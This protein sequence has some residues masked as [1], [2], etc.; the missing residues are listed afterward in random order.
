MAFNH[1][2]IIYLLCVFIAL[3]ILSLALWANNDPK[4][5]TDIDKGTFLFQC[6]EHRTNG[7]LD[8]NG[9]LD[10]S[11]W[12]IYKQQ[13]EGWDT[14]LSSLNESS[15]LVL[16]QEA[17]LTQELKNYI[18][19]SVLEVAMAHAFRLW[20]TAFGVM[21][22]SKVSASRV[23]A[24]TAT[25][26]LIRFAKSG[27]VAIYPLSNGSEL[28]VVNLHGINFEWNLTHYKKQLEALAV[29]L[30]EHKGPIILAGDFNT[31]REERMETVNKFAQRFNLIEAQYGIDERER[32]FGYPLD[33]LFFRGLI[34]EG[35]E[36]K[37]TESSDHNPI[38]AHFVL[39]AR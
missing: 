39:P 7:A 32:V 20:D 2:R 38:T 36:A 11:V 19:N 14:L 21:N 31:W 3:L 27:I 6:E 18:H 34:F 35:A 1:R 13:R 26:P 8:D 5:T 30:T 22:L 16:L 29:E 15:Q 25:E 12:N 28:L 23:C 17:S 9:Q 24:Y 37:L 33:H 4:V 10:V